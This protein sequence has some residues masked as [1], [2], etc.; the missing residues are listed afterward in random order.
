VT[1]VSFIYTI[2]FAVIQ[3]LFPV[4]N[5]WILKRIFDSV[6]NTTALGYPVLFSNNVIF[7][8][9]IQVFINILSPF[10]DELN[11]YFRRDTHRKI[12]A[13]IKTESLHK[14]DTLF[15][16]IQYDSP[17]FYDNVKTA[18][19]GAEFGLS[20]LLDNLTFASRNLITIFTFGAMLILI[21]PFLAGI[22]T[23][24]VIPQLY[25]RLFMN[26]E[27][28]KFIYEL[29]PVERFINYLQQ[30]LS[31]APAAKEIQL[32][33]N[34][35]YLLEKFVTTL[36]EFNLKEKQQEKRELIRESSS[37]LISGIV[38]GS[39]L[40]MV[41][42][43]TFMEQLT[44]G[45]ISLYLNAIQ[46][47][48]IS[49]SSLVFTYSRLN[50]GSLFFSRFQDLMNTPQSIY[51]S[52]IPIKMNRFMRSIKI[53]NLGFRYSNNQPWILRHL[54]LEIR[55]NESVALVGVNG[56]GKST[57]VKLIARLY[58]PNEGAILWNGLNI[59]DFD[60]R[61]YR[62]EIG[63]VFQDFVHYEMTV[64][65]N[66]GLGNVKFIKDNVLIRNAAIKAG[67]D[68]S[69]NKYP[70]LYE[71]LLTKSLS[72]D[73]SG[74]EL[75]GG[76]W[77]KIA[78]ARLFMRDSELFIF[79]EPTASLDAESESELHNYLLEVLRQKTCIVISHRL[80]ITKHVDKI[81]VLDNG[82]IVEYGSHLEL[83]R[84]KGKYAKLFD[85]Q[86]KQYVS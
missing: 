19:Q 77:Q 29:S 14:I 2:L 86:S 36:Q 61:E 42:F 33:G 41:V 20:D 51:V 46:N 63:I 1:P 5:A 58:D 60:V 48:S 78:L 79:D 3:G 64:N 38:N 84:L 13:S 76:E 45:D 37:N 66:I 40:I 25:I 49:L 68:H 83:M 71:T 7:L 27:R 59:R 28:F 67:I 35:K 80:S 82:A 65:E 22:V 23:L 50:Q 72:Q 57:L 81:A 53:E 17:S 8:L 31:S 62:S 75:S 39:A 85:L 4:V 56:S 54:N 24:S 70:R 32:F 44:I 55:N 12:N 16:V 11:A 74:I 26:K 43:Q 15:G 69:I 73:S 34:S 52:P 9:V 10:L 21:N 6:G 30:L 18:L 47:L